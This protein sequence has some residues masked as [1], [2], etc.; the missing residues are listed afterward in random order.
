MSVV[1]YVIVD[2]VQE[3]AL[4]QV[5]E[6]VLVQVRAKAL[7][8]K[9]RPVSK[10]PITVIVIFDGGE[11][12]SQHFQVQPWVQSIAGDTHCAVVAGH[13]LVVVLFLRQIFFKSQLVLFAYRRIGRSR[14][15]GSLSIH[16]SERSHRLCRR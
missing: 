10:F 3:E 6:L 1:L 11:A 13:N 14:I 2:D 7:H 4:Y 5:V 8:C 15:P 16:S 12:G 9:V